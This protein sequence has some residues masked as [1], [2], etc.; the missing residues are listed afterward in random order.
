[1]MQLGEMLKINFFFQNSWLSFHIFYNLNVNEE[2]KHQPCRKV[3]PTRRQAITIQI[4]NNHN[5]NFK[6]YALLYQRELLVLEC[7]GNCKWNAII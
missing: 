5:I 6:T 4:Q 7:E 1:M 3:S 2:G